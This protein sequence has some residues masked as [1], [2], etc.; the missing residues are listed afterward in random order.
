MIEVRWDNAEETIIRLDYADP[1]SNWEE[2]HGAMK[3]AYQ[4]VRSKPHT[5][6]MIHNPGNTKMPKGNA[7]V[8][9]RRVLTSAPPNT[10]LIIMIVTDGFARN[11]LEVLLRMTTYPNTRF[12]KTLEE[13]Y[14]LI[15]SE[16]AVKQEA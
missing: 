15:E 16:Q 5:I 7:L 4:W 10:G 11:V 1:V 2:Y 8:H 14:R 12:A 3:T 13:A 9:I 6:H